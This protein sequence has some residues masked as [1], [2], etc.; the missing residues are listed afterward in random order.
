VTEG[1]VANLAFTR[2]GVT[3]QA[4][5]W[6]WRLLPVAQADSVPADSLPP[7]EA[8]WIDPPT[9]ENDPIPVSPPAPSPN[10]SPTARPIAN[11]SGQAPAKRTILF[12]FA[13]PEIASPADLD[14]YINEVIAYLQ[15]HPDRK[16]RISGH[17]DDTASREANL[18]LG[19]NRADLIA[20][21]FRNKGLAENRM[22]VES[23][24]EK[25]P[26]APND[27]REGRALNRRTD[28]EIR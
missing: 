15:A 25:E 1:Q 20:E 10:P 11:P 17:T 12:S 8:E 18:R 14:R 7:A 2:E 3:A 26:V 23:V 16:V 28:I 21:L 6:D 27:T 22:L 19:Q 4:Y 13:K 24:G 9:S 5:H